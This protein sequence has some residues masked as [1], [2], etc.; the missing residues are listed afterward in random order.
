MEALWPSP[1]LEIIGSF[2]DIK[3]FTQQSGKIRKVNLVIEDTKE[4]LET[5]KEFSE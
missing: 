2:R 5:V 1:V 3:L 4:S